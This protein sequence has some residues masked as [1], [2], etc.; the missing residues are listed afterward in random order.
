MK[1]KNLVLLTAI[2]LSGCGGGSSNPDQIVEPSV[3]TGT[4]PQPTQS[5]DASNNGDAS[6]PAGT[7]NNDAA[8]D[9]DA[10]SDNDEV[11]DNNGV[12]DNNN[13]PIAD[14]S[15]ANDTNAPDNEP[16]E[17]IETIEPTETT[18]PTAPPADN[19]PAPIDTTPYAARLSDPVW[20]L[21]SAETG[22]NSS[23]SWQRQLVQF[24]TFRD[25]VKGCPTDDSFIPD[26][27]FPGL[28]WNNA[29]ATACAVIDSVPGSA[30][31]SV[32]LYLP[33]T[34]PARQT[35]AN[36]GAF[37]VHAGGG[38]WQC[39]HQRRNLSSEPFSNTGI[40]ISYR[41]Y[42]NGT[43]DTQNNA[44]DNQST[45]QWWFDGFTGTRVIGLPTDSTD[46]SL[47]PQRYVGNVSV[48]G[49]SMMIYRTTVDRLACTSERSADST[50]GLPES[51]TVIETLP[52]LAVDD[53]IGRPMSCRAYDSVALSLDGQ[54]FTFIGQR[55]N[56]ETDLSD[57]FINVSQSASVDASGE[58]RYDFQDGSTTTY[59][60]D[61]TGTFDSTF[62]LPGEVTRS[63]AF[64]QIDFRRY[65]D[66]LI[67][68]D[69]FATGGSGNSSRFYTYSLCDEIQ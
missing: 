45:E 53:L 69:L 68:T 32:P 10:A 49:N 17:S 65:N 1:R 8:L 62:R 56:L 22:I 44:T 6:D 52:R 25:C 37:Q 3:N 14:D 67:M 40:Q 64:H 46:E 11:I 27:D 30:L 60:V 9:N 2:T 41:F 20:R 61:D 16:I 7:L 19:Q 34:Q 26:P 24:D 43:V 4:T 58:S 66:Q 47:L 21:C 63:F 18:G 15:D 54:S 50:A 23:D 51:A 13:P 33:N 28:G 57:V 5:S 29:L 12:I 39:A 59:T 42:P 48:D 38:Q 36:I 55:S 31:Y 35:F